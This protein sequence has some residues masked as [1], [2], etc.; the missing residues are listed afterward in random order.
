M[1]NPKTFWNSQKGKEEGLSVLLGNFFF[2]VLLIVVAVVFLGEFF[3]SAH[4][5][6]MFAVLKGIRKFLL[7]TV[8]FFVLAYFTN[9]LIKT[10]G[11]EKN[12][13]I[14]RKLVTYSF[15]P[16]LL[17]SLVTGFSRFFIRWIF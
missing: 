8:G 13:K 9:I 15:T 16:L 2:P 4:F 14:A 11:G 5:Y 1:F 7:F 17:V 10:F 3:R 12:I 6:V